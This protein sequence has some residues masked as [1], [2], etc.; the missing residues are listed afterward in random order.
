[1]NKIKKLIF[2][3][4]VFFRDAFIKRYP[5]TVSDGNGS[6]ILNSKNDKSQNKKPVDDQRV[7]DFGNLPVTFPI[8]FVFTWVDSDDPDFIEVFNQ[9]APVDSQKSVLSDAARFKS[10]DELRYALRSVFDYA[11]WVNKVYIVT[12]GQYP[13]W[14]NIDHPKVR[15]VSHSEILEEKYLPTFNS[16]VI[17]SAIHKIEDLSE[18]YVYFNDDMML[19]RPVKPEYF[20]TGSGLAF[21]FTSKIKLPASPV[22]PVYDSATEWGAKNARRLIFSEY[23]VYT[24]QMFSHTFYPQLKSVA[25]LCEATWPDAFD[26]CRKNK[27]R[28]MNDL[29]CTGFLI[30]HVAQITGK[31]IFTKTRVFYFNIRKRVAL[32]YYRMLKDKKGKDTIPF[33]MCPNDRSSYDSLDFE[34]YAEHL[35]EALNSFYNIPSPLE[36][37]PKEIN[38]QE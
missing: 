26:A 24:D 36:L 8:D 30:P 33:S 22:N 20:F 25:Q 11:P 4:G 23:G 6:V 34:D 14:M 10:L 13:E 16:H 29:L 2:K 12:N 28:A 18:H 3:P 37:A 9:H 21:M 38:N 17:E 19:L 15:I 27:F 31:S 1:M 32:D 5:I 7:I 35:T